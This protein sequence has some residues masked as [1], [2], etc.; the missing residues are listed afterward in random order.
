MLVSVTKDVG[1]VELSYIASKHAQYKNGT[2][3]HWK[4]SRYS[5][6]QFK[7]KKLEWS[8]SMGLKFQLFWE[9]RQEALKLKVC[10]SNFVSLYLQM[11]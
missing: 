3:P 11:N 2:I 7:H 6:K 9:H 5:G 1:K 4:H 10:V 8:C